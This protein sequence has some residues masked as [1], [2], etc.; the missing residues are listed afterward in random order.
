MKDDIHD[1]LQEFNNK[2]SNNV[3]SSSQAILRGDNPEK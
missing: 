2:L 1:K 3:N